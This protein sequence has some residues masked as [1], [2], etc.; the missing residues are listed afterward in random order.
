MYVRELIEILLKSDQ[1]KYVKV[2]DMGGN[3]GNFCF[4]TTVDV[5]DIS[6]DDDSITIIGESYND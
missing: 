2:M 1:T 4:P 3:D 5:T 6:E